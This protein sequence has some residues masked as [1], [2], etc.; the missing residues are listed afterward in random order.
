MDIVEYGGHIPVNFRVTLWYN[1]H[2]Y[3]LF[4]DNMKDHT[5]WGPQTIGKLV[6]I[7]PITT[8]YDTYNYS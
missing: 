1:I 7:T 2:Y 8:V 6:Q 4:W 5:M 3:G